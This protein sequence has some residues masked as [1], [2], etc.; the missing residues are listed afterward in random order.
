M[1]QQSD[2]LAAADAAALS[3]GLASLAFFVLALLLI[4][5]WRARQNVR[6]LLVACLATGGWATGT[7][8]LVLLGQRTA[9]AGD[10]LELLRTLA[11][12]VFL[13]L[14]IEPSRPRLRLLL[15]GIVLT[16]LAPWLLSMASSWLA[17]PLPARIIASV[18]R[19][20]LAVLGMLLVEQW[21]RNTPPLKRW[22]I[23]FACLGV[24]GLFAYDFYLYSDALL[25]RTINDDIWAARGI[26]D[27]LCAPLLAVSAARNPGW[28][29][30]LSVS[31]Q[32]LYRSAALLGSAIYLL[33]MAA[34]AYYLR[35]FGGTWGSF[36]QM[37][38]LGGAALLLAGVLFSGS[39]RAK[40]KVYINKNFYNAI[41]DYREE[42]LRFTRAL[43]EDGPALGE[44]TIQAMAQLVESR[45]GALWILR[46][47]GQFA[48]AASWN[49]PPG[50]WSE[51]ALGPLCQFLE[52]R[53]WVIDVPDCQQNPRQYG[54]LRLPP[55][56]LALPD[57]WLLVPLMLHGQL[58]A[59]VALAR[60]RTRIGLNWE[61]RDVLKI[62]GSQAASYLAHRESLDT[63]TVARQFD[64]FNRMSTFIVH[65]LKNLVFQLSLLLSNAEK[66]R[67]NPAFQ[68]DMLGTLDHSVQKMK[69]LLQKL[70]RGEAP[71]APAPLQL[72]GL[73]RQAVAA[74][75]S[76]A[77][78]PRL[79]IV[80]G[81]L[82]VLAN[83]ARLERV[84]GH[85]IQN[86]IEATASDGKVAVRLRRVQHTAVVELD[87]TGQGMSE[88]FIRDRLF[89]PFDT[90]KTAGM[91]IGVFESREYLREVGGS[92]EVRSE[93]QVGT[94]F[95]VILPLHA[96]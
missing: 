54:G 58:F 30:G 51:P 61:I 11:W 1:R 88:Q 27:A 90:T 14:L 21:Y 35:Y 18:C 40:L 22:G 56:L 65:D 3:H 57:V 39:L 53:Q 89:T 80:D 84:L 71:E 47:Q 32:M 64:S 17:L 85:L 74:K 42:W 26:V 15:A 63:L 66:H 62:A 20:L 50:T 38:Y 92:L 76:L 8:V 4:S 43:S 69:T 73:L 31:R 60:P 55:A 23:K 28:A 29:L 78:A 7:V 25:F 67:A 96:A 70:A 37:A 41:F 36:M 86:A 49:W 79:E 24:G 75:A 68:E 19:L 77:P 81:E 91:G 33:A 13:L 45:A 6:A 2:W 44:R 72:D 16:A 48:P 95:R 12:L 52:A 9:L 46:E 87:D 94:T 59:F 34:S 10:A 5:N 83:R 93:P 82:T